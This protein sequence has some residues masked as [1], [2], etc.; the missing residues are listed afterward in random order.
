MGSQIVGSLGVRK[1][2]QVGFRKGKI[3][4]NKGCYRKKCSAVNLIFSSRIIFRFEITNKRLYVRFMH[5]Q[6]VTMLGSLKLR[7]PKS[8]ED[9]VYNWL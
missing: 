2:W 5:K 6:K 4:G 1:F 9:G 3:R 8:Y 7:L